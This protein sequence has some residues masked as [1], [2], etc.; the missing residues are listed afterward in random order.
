[1]GWCDDDASTAVYA[2]PGEKSGRVI[3]KFEASVKV[4]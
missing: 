2:L 3:R 1:M 4:Q